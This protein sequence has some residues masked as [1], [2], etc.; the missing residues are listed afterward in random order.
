[1]AD[2]EFNSD[3]FEQLSRGWRV[4]LD[5]TEHDAILSLKRQME[6]S[7]LTPDT[8]TVAEIVRNARNQA[9]ASPDMWEINQSGGNAVTYL[10]NP[11]DTNRYDV[12]VKSEMIRSNEQE[13]TL[14][15]VYAR[16]QEELDTFRAM[17]VDTRVTITWHER[18]DGTDP[19]QIWSTVV[20]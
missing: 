14:P 9:L 15:V 8:A 4:P 20:P 13:A 12:V 3:F 1:M 18:Q 6:E 16:A 5:G 10:R 2:I 17:G 11:S 19:E 7:G